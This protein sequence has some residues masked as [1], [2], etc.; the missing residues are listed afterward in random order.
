MVVVGEHHDLLQRRRREM[1]TDAFKHRLRFRNSIEGTISEF[2]R[3]G[4][5]RTRYRGLAKTALAN[6]FQG[7]AIN[8]RRWISLVQWQQEVRKPTA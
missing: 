3:G 2:T 4:G 5:R 6:H 1:K 7:A 8:A